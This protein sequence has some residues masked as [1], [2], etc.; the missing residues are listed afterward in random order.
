[1]SPLM[2]RTRRP[3]AATVGR[4]GVDGGGVEHI[5][6]VVADAGQRAE[7]DLGEAQIGDRARGR[8]SRSRCRKLMVEH[9]SRV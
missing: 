7:V 4:D 5:G 8:A 3:E 6:D 9:P 1:M 2:E